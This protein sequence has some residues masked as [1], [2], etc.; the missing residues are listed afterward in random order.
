MTD[1]DRFHPSAFHLHTTHTT[2]TH[3]QLAGSPLYLSLE[4]HL[5]LLLVSPF[6][7][8]RPL[9]RVDVSFA[10]RLVR[11]LSNQPTSLGLQGNWCHWSTL[12]SNQGGKETQRRA[13]R[14]SFG[15]DRLKIHHRTITD[16]PLWPPEPRR[17]SRP[18]SGYNYCGLVAGHNR[19][20]HFSRNP[21]WMKL[22]ILFD[23]RENNL[24]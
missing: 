18:Q 14:V 5:L 24:L 12:D 13:R 3:T 17:F 2:P 16:T 1:R 21:R 11:P 22:R 9:F 23:H 15:V 6:I 7:P 19:R 4:S 20:Q 10:S 8:P